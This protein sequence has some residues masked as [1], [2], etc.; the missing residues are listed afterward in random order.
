M[1][2]ACWAWSSKRESNPCYS[3]ELTICPGSLATERTTLVKPLV[4]L[5][6]VPQETTQRL[7]PHSR[8]SWAVR[9][10]MRHGDVGFLAFTHSILT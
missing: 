4:T 5:L 1:T 9:F 6:S 7:N 8:A 2:F 3:T 10:N